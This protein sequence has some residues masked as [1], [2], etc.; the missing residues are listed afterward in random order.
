[1]LS[2]SPITSI[3]KKT[4]T[5]PTPEEVALPG[6]EDAAVA[7]QVVVEVDQT[8]GK[9][10]VQRKSVDVVYGDDG[11]I[12]L[13]I[14]GTPIG[15]GF[16][17]ADFV[18][19]SYLKEVDYDEASNTLTFTVID[20]DDNLQDIPVDLSDLVDVYNADDVS[21]TKEGTT[22]KIK[23]NGVTTAKIADK[24]VTEAKLSDDVA[25]KLNKEWQPVG[26]YKTTQTAVS[27]PTANGK[28]LTFI[29]TIAQNA[30][31][32]ITATKKEVNLDD[33]ALKGELPTVNDGKF[34][35]S[36]AG[37]LTG[38]GEMTAN[39]AENTSATLDLTAE[40]K[41]K[42]D[43]AVQ[44]VT[45]G[46]GIKATKTGTTVNLEVVGKG[47]TD[48]DGNEVVWVFDCGGAE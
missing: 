43:N 38:T 40:A 16:N 48:D 22:F 30:N 32:E 27:D 20:N 26:N 34:T 1:M 9:I 45:A 29:D 6:Y 31:G 12:K 13:A 24:N 8:A 7:G 4:I 15:T 35:V 18:K 47:E 14:D 44:T 5:L 36:G 42:I 23:D 17:A 3:N 2:V 28:S 10:A 21:L 39:Q 19:D 41:G 25:A 11:F 37:Y 46:V 33:Y